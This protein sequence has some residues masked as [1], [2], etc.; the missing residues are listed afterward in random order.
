MF[1]LIGAI[2]HEKTGKVK[3]IFGVICIAAGIVMFVCHDFFLRPTRRPGLLEYLAQELGQY[4]FALI[5]ILPGIVI[6][7]WGMIQRRNNNTKDTQL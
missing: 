7:G 6:A 1:K 2:F 3:M 4:G 5:Y